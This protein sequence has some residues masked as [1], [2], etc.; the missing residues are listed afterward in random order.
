MSP[1][2]PILTCLQ[3]TGHMAATTYVV[4]RA[5]LHF[6]CLQHWIV[7]VYTPTRHHIHKR[8]T[9]PS[10]VTISLRWWTEPRNL[11]AGVPFH[12]PQPSACITTDASLTGWGAHM[13]GMSVQG[14]WSPRETTFHI[15]ILELRAVFNAC[16]HFQVPIRDTTVRILTD[17]I[18]MMYYINCQGGTGS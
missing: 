5:R 10:A 6:S 15:S 17:N 4:H 9:P 18:S 14:R 8:V 7:S 12:H 1:T 2:V 11:L 16:K 3:L 13:N